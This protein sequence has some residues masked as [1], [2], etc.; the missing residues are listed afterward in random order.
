[1]TTLF[2]MM[3]QRT[4]GR[5]KHNRESTLNQYSNFQM[6]RLIGILWNHPITVVLTCLNI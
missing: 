4:S 2:G 1:M 6:L 5:K 3:N